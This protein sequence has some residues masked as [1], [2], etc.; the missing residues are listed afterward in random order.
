[1]VEAHVK[2]SKSLSKYTL[3]K[4]KAL[5]NGDLLR[6]IKRA[7]EKHKRISF[8]TKLYLCK[9]FYEA[10]C[11]LWFVEK[12]VLN[13]LK[14]DNILISDCFTKLLLC[15]FGHATHYNMVLKT[16]VGTKKYRAP[17][18]NVP[19]LPFSAAK[20]EIPPFSAA[21]AEVFAFASVLFTIF[22][23]KFPF[24]EMATSTDSLYKL[25]KAEEYEKFFAFHI[26]SEETLV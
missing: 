2:V 19:A 8:Q 26:A 12:K 16:Y 24:S 1:M 7:S 3:M 22:F 15:D 20:A 14:L 10:C 25:I 9:K 5:K 18:I 4:F 23:E 6:L 21:K 13:D 11:H 17:E